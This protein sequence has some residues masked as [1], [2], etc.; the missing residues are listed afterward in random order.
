MNTLEEISVHSKRPKKKIWEHI[1]QGQTRHAGIPLS[2]CLSFTLSFPCVHLKRKCEWF[3][4]RLTFYI[5]PKLPIFS[6][7]FTVRFIG[8]FI[9]YHIR[10]TT[11]DWDGTAPHAVEFLSTFPQFA[12]PP[13]RKTPRQPYHA[14]GTNTVPTTHL[15]RLFPTTLLRCLKCLVIKCGNKFPY[16]L[17]NDRIITNHY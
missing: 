14:I 15:P 10:G 17:L 4:D 5:I 7:W 1:K 3:G 13:R 11:F 16:N 9:F 12:L 2:V 6:R 8:W